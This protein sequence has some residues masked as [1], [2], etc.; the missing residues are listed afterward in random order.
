[1][2]Y[3]KPETKVNQSASYIKQI[4]DLGLKGA[5][6]Q[7]WSLVNHQ[8]RLLPLT[9][10]FGGAFAFSDPDWHA[11]FELALA[12]LLQGDFQEKWEVAKIFPLLGTKIV[13]P[14][15]IILEDDTVDVEVRWFICRILGNFAEPEVIIALIG[16]L[17]QTEAE[18]IDIASQTLTEIGDAAIDALVA[19]LSQPQ[20]R[21]LAVKSLAC[22]RRWEIITPLIG[23]VRDP[24]AEIR[25][26]AIEALGS[27]HN[28]LIPP[29]LIAALQDTA[30]SVR[31]E[32]AI[33]LGF[34][35]DLCIKLDLVTHLQ[36]LLYDLNLEVC[37]QAAIALSRMKHP[38][39]V[40]A[41]F[42][43]LQS[44][45]TPV[46]LQL[47]LVRALGW[48]EL[49]LAIDY[50]GQTLVIA[51]ES[52]VREII[53]VLGRISSS[54]LK[55]RAA[56]ILIDF[57]YSHLKRLDSP[58]IQ[59]TL[60]LS[61]GELGNSAAKPYLSELATE[62]NRIVRLHAIAALKKLSL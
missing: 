11:T 53:A 46:E 44:T 55:V 2:T 20:Y 3:S 36:P 41:L 8:L 21:L 23:V 5:E 4:L 57:G 15:I 26:L 34:R 6:Q 38:S 22:I 61:L 25:T 27:F 54:R 10:T 7:N 47:D 12:V 28:E 58:Q 50:L 45:H 60:A 14:L 30:S 13:K 35:R 51:S 40:K 16:L 18:L 32:A 9:Q 62:D 43:V 31:R 49:E 17:Q 39:A 52:V 59:Q 29:I 42:K 33:A 24:Q 48:S 37:R 19:L 1:M 56:Q